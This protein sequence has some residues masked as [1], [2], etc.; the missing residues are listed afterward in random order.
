MPNNVRLNPR[1][2]YDALPR[3]D[4]R[5]GDIWRGLPSFGIL[6]NSNV[7][8]LVITPAC[9]LS[10][11][12]SET[13]TFLPLCTVNEYLGSRAF[14]YECWLEIQPLFSRLSG[15]DRLQEP[16]R[17]DLLSVSS[18]EF[19]KNCTH[20]SVGKKLT[21]AELGRLSAYLKYLIAA[22]NGSANASNLKDFFKTDKFKGILKKLVEN[23]LKPDI[24]FLPSDDLPIEYSAVGS[25]SIVLF[26]YP[27]SLPIEHLNEV[28][29]MSSEE[30]WWAHVQKRKGVEKVL[31]SFGEWP[32]KLACLRKEFYGDLLS[33]YVNMFVRLG[34]PD[35]DDA[36]VANFASEI[37]SGK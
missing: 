13:I 26:R 4:H 2:F 32:I 11:N 7:R 27:L 31:S 25:H 20:D 23:S 17:Y 6:K 21:E 12:K 22:A 10:N 15:Y 24:H 3:S 34:S 29:T 33:R 1:D 19:A 36:S 9:D 5:P 16:R 18:L 30:E 37:E 8:G 28:R 14:A 35:F